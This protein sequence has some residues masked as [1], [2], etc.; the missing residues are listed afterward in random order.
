MLVMGCSLDFP[1]R[2]HKGVLDSYV[3]VG[4]GVAFCHGTQRSE[5]FGLEVAGCVADGELE[6]FDAAR[7]V[8]EGN[9]YAA[10]EPI[11]KLSLGTCILS[12]GEPGRVVTFAE[13]QSLAAMGYL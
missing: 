6:H 5:V 12:G 9:V 3:D 4:S 2:L 10:L 8:R 7:K 1:D 11:A 13:W